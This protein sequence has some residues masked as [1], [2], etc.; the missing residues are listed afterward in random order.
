MGVR[1]GQF[2]V[3]EN[4]LRGEYFGLIVEEEID[5]RMYEIT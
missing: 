5:I 4:G 2:A 3:F 1:F